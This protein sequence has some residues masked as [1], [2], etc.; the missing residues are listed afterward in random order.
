MLDKI[1]SFVGIAPMDDPE[2]IVLAALDTPSRSTGIYISGGVMA[3]PTVGAVMGDILPYLGVERCYEP[4]DAA[5]REVTLEDYRGLTRKEAE[6][7]AKAQGLSCRI[8]GQGEKI[9]QQVPEAGQQLP[10]TGQV[11]L[12][13]DTGPQS[14]EVS[15]PDLTGKNRQQCTALAGQLGLSILPDGNPE[16]SGIAVSQEPAPGETTLIGNSVRVRFA[17]LSASD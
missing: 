9:T 5:A 6:Q 4:E 12:Y 13:L 2:Y 8:L 7:K 10:G 17:D 15:V 14:R 1:V 16:L 3:A 11:L